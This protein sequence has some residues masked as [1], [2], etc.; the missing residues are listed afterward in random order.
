MDSPERLKPQ[1]EPAMRAAVILPAVSIE[2]VDAY[3]TLVKHTIPGT[4]T[5]LKA[6]IDA[7][8]LTEK[9]RQVY[10]YYSRTDLLPPDDDE[11]ARPSPFKRTQTS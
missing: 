8:A 7:E 5:V 3:R 10:E 2:L 6:L 1:V 11:T 9:G 4:V